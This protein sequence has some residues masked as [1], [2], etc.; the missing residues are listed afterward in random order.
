MGYQVAIATVVWV[1]S[2]IITR[3]A[4]R[5]GTAAAARAL[6]IQTMHH[7][8]RFVANHATQLVARLGVAHALHSAIRSGARYRHAA[9]EFEISQEIPF[10]FEVN[11]PEVKADL[12]Q[13]KEFIQGEGQGDAL[14]DSASY[15]A[16]RIRPLVPARTGRVRGSVGYRITAQD[17]SSIEAEVGLNVLYRT[18]AA[19]YIELGTRAHVIAPGQKRALAW[20]RDGGIVMRAHVHHPG[21]KG[22]HIVGKTKNEEMHATGEI[23]IQRLNQKLAAR[24]R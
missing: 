14:R 10:G 3:A 13:A 8:E 24:Y 22:L 18:K 16:G 23:Y 17:D 12:A 7:V 1:G 6:S 21:T 4:L 5:A 19:K 11:G 15:L 20:T 2:R 9:G